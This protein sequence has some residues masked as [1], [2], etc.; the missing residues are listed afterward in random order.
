[1]IGALRAR[2][3]AQLRALLRQGHPV[4]PAALEGWA[5][6]GTVLAAPAFVER[7]TWQTFQKAFHRQPD[8]GRLVGWNVRVHQDGAGAPSRP[9]TRRGV[10]VTAWP[11]EV[12]EPRERVVPPG[13]DRGLLIDYAPFAGVADS[14]RAVKDPLVS[15]APGNADTLL[16]VSVVSLGGVC[17]ETP[18]W[19]VLEREHP[20]RFVPPPFAPGALL[21][22]FERRWADALFDAVLGTPVDDRERFWALLAA[23]GPAALAPGL[24]LAVHT[25]TF[26][27]LTLRGFRRPFF[28]LDAPAQLACIEVMASHPRLLVRQVV[29]T[30]KVLASFA[31]VEAPGVRSALAAAAGPAGAQA[32]GAR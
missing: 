3:R 13:F 22:A 26:L 15:L 18:T 17:V 9:R 2:S 30:L 10:P 25:L 11:F 7:L 19:F 27:P 16:G 8:T 1:M 12:V 31:L 29:S 32:G 24:R 4:D 14:M 6:R 28:A 20:V 21:Q 23:H 5:Y